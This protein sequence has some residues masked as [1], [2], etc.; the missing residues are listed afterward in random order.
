MIFINTHAIKLKNIFMSINHHLQKIFMELEF[1]LP[2][3]NLKWP[4]HFI[5]IHASFSSNNE[6]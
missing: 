6:M 3:S 1:I 5:L 2:P 4:I